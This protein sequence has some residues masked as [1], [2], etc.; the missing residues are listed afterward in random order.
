VSLGRSRLR[1]TLDTLVGSELPFRARI[2]FL[3]HGL[4]RRAPGRDAYTLGIG[5]GRVFLSYANDKTD[6]S[7]LREIFLRRCYETDLRDAYVV[8]V[9]AHKGYFGAYA[10][11]RGASAVSSYEPEDEN[12]RFLQRTAETFHDTSRSWRT[13]RAAVGSQDGE[14]ELRVSPES[15]SH[16]VVGPNGSPAADGPT[17]RVTGVSIAAVLAQAQ[18]ERGAR[19]LV[20]KV[21]AEGAECAIVLQTPS[22]AWG[23][24]DELFLEAHDFAACPKE[25]LRAHFE[26]IGFVLRSDSYNVLHLARAGA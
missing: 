10:F 7:V 9:G 6:R 8:D 23:A 5:S 17:Q 15:W 16:A 1:T 2:D 12:F 4:G 19:R 3:R 14:V 24:V 21:D 11:M 13:T 25:A 26:T 22:E 20:V 18:E